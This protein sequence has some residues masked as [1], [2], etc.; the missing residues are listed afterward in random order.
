[1]T[2]DRN[3]RGVDRMI[4]LEVIDGPACAPRP[5]AQRAPIVDGA[6]LSFIDQTD[7]ALGEAGAVIGLDAGGVEYGVAPAL[8]ENLLLPRRTEIVGGP[9]RRGCGTARRRR[10][11][12]GA[13]A[14]P[15]ELY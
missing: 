7:D 6:R 1:M 13:E 2:L 3:V 14:E 12:A 10:S 9:A 15:A 5:C 11:A 4:G 8:C